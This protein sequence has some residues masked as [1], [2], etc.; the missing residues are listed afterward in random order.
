MNGLPT[1]G[2]KEH[3]ETNRWHPQRKREIMADGSRCYGQQRSHPTGSGRGRLG[4]G[5]QRPGSGIGRPIAVAGSLR[6][7]PTC[8]K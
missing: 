2:P 4:D 3:R 7:L 6:R 1:A 8:L 5:A